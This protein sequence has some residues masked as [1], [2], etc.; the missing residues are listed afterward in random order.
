MTPT[1]ER[2]LLDATAAGLDDDLRAAYRRL[3]ELIGEGMAPRDA[4]AAVM[5][6]FEGEYAQLLAD[7]FGAILE[8][9]VGSESVLALQVGDVSLS[10]N[11][12]DASSETA[13]VVQ[14]IVE[15]HAKGWQDARALTL[16]I[17]EGYGFNASEPLKWSRRNP[18]LPRYMREALM[19]DMGLSSD[20]KRHFTRLQAEKLRTPALRASYLEA[21]D[22]LEEGRGEKVLARKLEV[23]FQERMRYHANR[24]AQTELHR[25]YAD[26]QA[27]EL[28]DDADVEFVQW[29]MSATHPRTD[30]CDY[31]A[32]VDRFGLGPG[33]FPKALAPKAPA[34]PFCRCVL[35]PCLDIPLGTPYVDNPEAGRAWLQQQ[36]ISVGAEVVGSRAKRLMALS[37]ADPVAVYNERTDPRY[38]ILTVGEVERDGWPLKG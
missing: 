12:Y 3:I 36:P 35:A 9:S 15:R 27:V 7:G 34:H 30:I 38:R 29:R 22:A 37:G 24:I 28:M 13:A 2:A 32:K 4:V 25:A 1:Q 16:Q 14:G 23:A 20:L 33:V 26:R 10:A 5:E 18:K 19:T 8:R 21:I 11:L 31:F 17:Y 6:T